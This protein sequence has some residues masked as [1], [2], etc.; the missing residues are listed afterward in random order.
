M[1]VFMIYFTFWIHQESGQLNSAVGTIISSTFFP[2]LTAGIGSQMLLLSARDSHT[3]TPVPAVLGV[4]PH[5]SPDG[6][7]Y[8]V[9]LI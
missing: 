7:A 2:F 6:F 5:V 9:I 8:G 1:K 4:E 3:A